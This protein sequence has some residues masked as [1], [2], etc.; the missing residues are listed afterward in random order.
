MGEGVEP[1]KRWSSNLK[2]VC[3]LGLLVFIVMGP[4][5]WAPFVYDDAAL[6]LGNPDVTGPW[7]GLLHF[8]LTPFSPEEAYEPVIVAMHRGL[9]YLVGGAPFWYRLTSLLIHWL[10][11]SLLLL[12]LRELIEPLEAVFLLAALF[13]VYPAHTEV[14]AISTFKKHLIVAM[15]GL[16]MLH[17]ERPW[18]QA[19]ASPARRAALFACLALALMTKEHGLMLPPIVLMMSL[20]LAPNWRDRLRRDFIFYAGLL[21]AC[22]FFV[23]WRSM[24]VPRGMTPIIGAS[25]TVHLLTS[26]KIL[27][28]YLRELI[29]PW[30]LCQEHWLHPVYAVIS[31]EAAGILAALSL[32]AAGLAALWKR[33]RVAFCGLAMALLWLAPCLNLVPYLNISLV[34]NRYLYLA[35]AGVLLCAGRLSALAWS[36]KVGRW[37]APLLAGTG[38]V[39]LYSGIAMRNLGRYSDPVDLWARAAECAP[40]HA[41]AH[42][43]SAGALA[44]RMRWADAERE[45]RLACRYGRGIAVASRTLLAQIYMMRGDCR[46]AALLAEGILRD[47]NRYGNDPEAARL[48]AL[49]RL[50]EGADGKAHEALMLAVRL[51]PRDGFIRLNLGLYYKRTGQIRRAEINWKVAKDLPGSRPLALNLLAELYGERGR[52]AESRKAY[53]E[54]LAEQP[55]QLSAVNGLALIHARGGHGEKGRALFD[56]L[57]SRLHTGE[58]ARL[59]VLSEMSPAEDAAMRSALSAAH[60]ARAKFLARYPPPSI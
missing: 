21:A 14:L 41:R 60:A 44:A 55:L 8:F 32:C 51:N 1:S 7:Q 46:H 57:I 54:S 52:L 26:A 30:Q 50:E 12:L 35:F 48:L 25:L 33:D 49:C 40:E 39:L 2:P 5:L 22:L 10:N 37:P 13:A 56:D 23:W 16:L 11:C 15:C 45:L 38:V 9:F 31:W 53:E 20:A 42:L 24:V 29:L 43:N 3:G 34:A 59:K 36:I 28:W 18:R 47:G 4:A 17:L 6:I 27:L 19:Q 58:A